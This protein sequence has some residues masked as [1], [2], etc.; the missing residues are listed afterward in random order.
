[1]HTITIDDDSIAVS[2]LEKVLQKADPEGEHIGVIC[3]ED[4]YDYIT[5]HNDIDIAFIDIELGEANG[6]NVI[7]KAKTINPE[8]N[9]VIYSGHTQYK[10]DAMDLH[11]S[12]FIEKP[13]N[14]QKLNVALENLRHPIRSRVA[15][16]P[17]RIV[18]FGS[19][20]VYDRQGNPMSF[21]ISN[22][23]A[24]FA[25]LVDQGGYPVTSHDI[26]ADVFERRKFD[27][28]TSKDISKYVIALM[29]DLEREGYSDIVIKQNKTVKI[30]K[31][32]IKCDLYE[33]LDGKREAVAAY[34]GDYMLDFSWAETS[35][36]KRKLDD[37]LN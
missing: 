15:K 11:V 22:S 7:K 20:V 5:E 9:I 36:N 13:V 10:A 34:R 29:R 24:V 16:E 28:Q 30:N 3:V 6:L 26:A 2:T 17:L 32:R 21:S 8:M 37:I 31:A 19:F 35:Q 27:K 1:M 18:T 23:V 12:S 4:F 25:Y 33:A 14:E